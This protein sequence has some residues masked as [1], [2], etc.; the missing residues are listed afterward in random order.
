MSKRF[1]A[2]G[3]RVHML[4][5]KAPVEPVEG[6]ISHHAVDLT[7]IAASVEAFRNAVAEAQGV[8]VLI[9]NAGVMQ[10]ENAQDSTVESVGAQIAV[11]L[12]APIHLTAAAIGVMQGQESGGHILNIASV[13]ALKASP[14]LAVYSAAKAGLI[15]YTKSVAA[16]Q[17]AKRIRANVICPGAVQTGLANRFVWAMIQKN[18]P[19]GKLQDAEEVASLAEWLLSADARHVTGSVFS[20]D[21]GMSL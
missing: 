15:A 20:L 19:L 9:N 3:H 17:A 2:A 21:G 16:E 13:A 12:I 7:D 8:D 5:R 14:K 10:F 4:S 11:N 6:S 18:V 1:A